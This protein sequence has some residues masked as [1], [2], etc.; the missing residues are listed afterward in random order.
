MIDYVFLVRLNH[1]EFLQVWGRPPKV[2]IPLFLYLV[3]YSQKAGNPFKFLD[4]FFLN[5]CNQPLPPR[6]QSTFSFV[7]EFDP[8]RLSQSRSRESFFFI[9]P[10]R[11]PHDLHGFFLIF[12]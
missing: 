4:L 6:T 9:L 2:Y 10:S 7:V 11:L 1:P 3:L 5:R 8:S 12:E